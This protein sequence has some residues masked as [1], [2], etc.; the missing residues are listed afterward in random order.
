V[1]TNRLSMGKLDR[2]SNNKSKRACT[3]G[4]RLLNMMIRRRWR[5][6]DWRLIYKCNG[7]IIII[8]YL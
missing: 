6:N 3:M 8:K 5:R 7:F 1:R 2:I 4:I